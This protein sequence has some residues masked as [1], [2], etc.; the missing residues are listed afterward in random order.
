[1]VLEVVGC[2]E[3]DE[4]EDRKQVVGDVEL[5]VRDNHQYRKPVR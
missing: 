3:K 4:A 5:H 1:M 2:S